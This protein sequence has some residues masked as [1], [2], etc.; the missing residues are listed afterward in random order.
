MSFS[1]AFGP[2]LTRF[3]EAA[4]A[5]GH[6]IS[7]N[8]GTRTAEQQAAIIGN[9][10]HKFGF[11]DRDRQSWLADVE[12]YGAIQAGERWS[13][14][15]TSARRTVGGEGE[16]GTPMRNWIALPG[17][18]NHQRGLAADLGYGSDAARR[19]AHDNAGDFDLR[20]PLANE[21]WH[22]EPASA[23][24]SGRPTRGYAAPNGTSVA[25]AEPAHNHE[26]AGGS[27][28]VEAHDAAVAGAN[29]PEPTPSGAENDA[30]GDNERRSYSMVMAANSEQPQTPDADE[31]DPSEKYMDKV[32][33]MS[34][35]NAMLGRHVNQIDM[36]ART[37]VDQLTPQQRMIEQA[38]YAQAKRQRGE[39]ASF[40]EWF[41]RD[42]FRTYLAAYATG[43]DDLLGNLSQQQQQLLANVSSMA[44]DMQSYSASV[45]G[46]V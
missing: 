31:L 42:R 35:D 12:E 21:N 5:A 15:F 32:V 3:L 33:D 39:S 18:S 44:D 13:Q 27:T 6:S 9:N 10:M 26:H 30:R 38:Q 7:I 8:S 29:I 24:D 37:F 22:I 16:R 41:K 45:M 19:W 17:S 23:R 14:R 4:E 34:V 1:D 36:V 25:S 43:N 40:D 28:S 2:Q 46:L 11:S 20:F